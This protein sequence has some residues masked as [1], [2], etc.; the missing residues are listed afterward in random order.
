MQTWKV[1]GSE[2]NEP[3]L[4]AYTNLQRAIISFI[5]SVSLSVICME[6]LGSHWTDFHKNYF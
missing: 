5:M 3:L 2:N 4:G 6:Q 1:L